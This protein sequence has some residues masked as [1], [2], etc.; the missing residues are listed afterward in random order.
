MQHL[1]TRMFQE[2]HIPACSNL[3]EKNVDA[4]TSHGKKRQKS[5]RSSRPTAAS[6]DL[7][8][9]AEE[10]VDEQGKTHNRHLH[11]YDE[12]ILCLHDQ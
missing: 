11:R 5:K 2:E 9:N 12:K 6:G 3:P 7:H 1:Q 8:R 10:E 4:G